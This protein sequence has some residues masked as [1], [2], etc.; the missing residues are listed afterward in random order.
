MCNKNIKLL[1]DGTIIGMVLGFMFAPKSG[2]ETRK[3]VCDFILDM[4]KEFM[5]CINEMEKELND[6]KMV[7]SLKEGID[8]KNNMMIKADKIVDKAIKK[9]NKKK[10]EQAEELKKKVDTVTSAVLDNL[11]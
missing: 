8:K 5:N 4:D 3:C 7:D 9:G 10:K 1:L 2:K 6:F 11:E